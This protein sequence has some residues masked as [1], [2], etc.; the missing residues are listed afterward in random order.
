MAGGTLSIGAWNNNGTDGPL[1][2]SA[3]KVQLSNATILYTGPSANV[4]KSLNM[5]GAGTIDVDTAGAMLNLGAAG[6]YTLTGSGNITKEGP[7][8]LQFAQASVGQWSWSGKLIIN[9][10]A[11]DFFGGGSMPVPGTTTPDAIQIND[12][13][14][15]NSSYSGTSTIDARTG[16]QL[17]GNAGISVTAGT[18]AIN[19][20]IAD[21]YC[22]PPAT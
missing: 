10:G 3:N 1:G 15:S 20:T 7:G 9:D 2:N 14:P 18:H 4:N 5:A 13:G 12:G 8:T 21:G 6:S 19:G 16:F 17:S 22:C 11:V